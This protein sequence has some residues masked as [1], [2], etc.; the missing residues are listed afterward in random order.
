MRRQ[1]PGSLGCDAAFAE[2]LT[3]RKR[4]R[5]LARRLLSKLPVL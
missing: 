4:L 3:D 2:R 5:I 1:A